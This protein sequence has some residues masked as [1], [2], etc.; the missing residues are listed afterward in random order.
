VSGFV[1]YTSGVC[2]ALRDVFGGRP[3]FHG[4]SVIVEEMTGAELKSRFIIL[5][6]R[7]HSQH[8]GAIA[9]FGHYTF[10]KVILI[11]GQEKVVN[12]VSVVSSTS[13]FGSTRLKQA[14]QA[15]RLNLRK[16]TKDPGF[17]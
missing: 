6:C 14:T 15:N 11:S 13:E 8:R 12:P 10:A 4:L 7:Q 9:R 16:A 1:R 5:A 3:Q 2:A 17:R